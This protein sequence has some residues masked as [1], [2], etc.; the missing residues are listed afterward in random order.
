MPHAELMGGLIVV[1]SHWNDKE[2]V[3]R[4]PGARW[5]AEL[6]AWTLAPSWASCVQLRYMFPNTMT[7]GD[8][9]RELIISTRRDRI[10]PSLRLRE[11]TN[12]DDAGKLYPFQRAGVDWL[13]VAGSALLADEMGTGKTIQILTLF[14]ELPDALPALVICPNSTKFNWRDEA[15]KWYPWARSYVVNGSAAER[16]KILKEAAQD[17][18]ALVIINIEAVRSHSRLAPFGSIRLAACP[19]CGGHDPRTTVARCEVHPR[20][21][22]EI[23]FKTVVVDEAHRIKDP[24]AKQ[25]RASWAV[26][27][28]KTVVRRFALTG[29]PIANDPSELWSI[30]HFIDPVEYPR[31]SAFV[32]RYC[33]VAWGTYGGLEVK[34]VNPEHRD[35][36]YQILDPRFRRMIKK[37]VLPQLPPKIPTTRLVEL[38]PK[39]FKAYR[40]IEETLVTRLADGTLMVAK[41]DLVAQIRLLQFSSASMQSTPDGFRMCD[42]SPKVDALIEIFE[43]RAGRPFVAAA[44]H[45]QLVELASRRLEKLGV[46]HGL[47]T[48]GQSTYERNAILNDLQARNLPVMLFTLKAGGTGLTMTAT[49]LIVF[50]QRSWS[51]V[52]NVQ[53]E[54]RVHRIGSEIH[55]S[56]QVIDLVAR[57]TVE[58]TQV[59]RLWEK[60]MRLDEITRDRA[61]LAAAGLSTVELDAEEQRI[62]ESNLGD[63]K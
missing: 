54:D 17:D 35:E 61:R 44:E 56:I 22:N 43:E 27:H 55:E 7:Y 51:M 28:G 16:A 13:H 41:D 29:T 47:I 49:D 14:N 8:E 59:G 63:A 9:L 52:D 42:P 20:Q 2:L 4:I 31:K 18:A 21:L 5:K 58:E 1:Q 40:E 33:L 32:D 57:G 11:L 24:H 23:P 19:D 30:G 37:I 39:Q 12:A 60:A 62:L 15:W 34:G 48:G 25:T 36:F 10:E 38:T 3:K 50:M 45:R 46:R 6:K 26:G 53:A